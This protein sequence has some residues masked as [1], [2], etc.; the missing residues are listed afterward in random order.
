MCHNR[1]ERWTAGI[2]LFEQAVNLDPS[3]FEFWSTLS[4]AY[5][6][7]GRNQEAQNAGIR[8]LQLNPNHPVVHMNLGIIAARMG[9][10]QDALNALHWLRRHDTQLAQRLE[11]QLVSLDP[12]YK[13][14]PNLA[15]QPVR[16]DFTDKKDAGAISLLGVEAPKSAA[17]DGWKGGTVD[18]G[19]IMRQTWWGNQKPVEGETPAQE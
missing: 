1:M 9:Y 3:R 15:P 13:A 7:A 11:Q 5:S 16:E 14:A 2:P 18:V 8:A 10:R 4:A 6:N 17:P 12:S 19:E